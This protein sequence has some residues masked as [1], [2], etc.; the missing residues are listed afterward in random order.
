MS[1]LSSICPHCSKHSGAS[2]FVRAAMALGV[3]SALSVTLMAC[4]GAPPCD[5]E[6]EKD[7]DGA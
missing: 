6:D 2:P 5:A 1:P 3:G 7:G 4:Y